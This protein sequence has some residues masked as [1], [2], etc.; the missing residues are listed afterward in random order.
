MSS[1]ITPSDVQFGTYLVDYHYAGATWT[2]EIPATSARDAMFRL[3]HAATHGA[4][5]GELM[6]TI[7][8]VPSAGLLT[9][10]ICWWRNL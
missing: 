7:P 6:M 5:A 2:I 9:R 1:S 3:R 4:V 8:A 10:L